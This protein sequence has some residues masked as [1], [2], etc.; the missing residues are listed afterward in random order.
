M[1]TRD[2]NELRQEKTYGYKPPMTEEKPK[3]YT[4]IDLET[5]KELIINKLGKQYYDIIFQAVCDEMEKHEAFKQETYFTLQGMDEFEDEWF[6]FYHEHHGDILHAVIN[7][8]IDHT[9]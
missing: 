4:E 6:E 5:T 8:G 2:M 1:K 9:N 7:N 3:G